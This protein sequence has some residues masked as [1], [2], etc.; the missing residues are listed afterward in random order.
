M[1]SAFGKEGFLGEF[2]GMDSRYG[3]LKAPR[4]IYGMSRG[5]IRMSRE[6]RVKVRLEGHTVDEHPSSR[7]LESR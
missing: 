6:G 2:D 3:R 4:G 1:W 7:R 5:G